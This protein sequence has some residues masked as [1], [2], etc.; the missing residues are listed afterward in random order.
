M[1]P[2]V[3]R[4]ASQSAAVICAAPACS[5][6]VDSRT[7]D[8]SAAEEAATGAGGG[9]ASGAGVLTGSGG[10][11]EAGAGAASAKGTASAGLWSP[12]DAATAARE[13]SLVR[14]V[15]GSADTEA[16]V[17]SDDIS[18]E[19]RALEAA[20]V[21]A[22]SATC[23]SSRWIRATRAPTPSPTCSD[24]SCTVATSSSTRGSGA[25]RI[26]VRAS[27]KSSMPRTRPGAPAR[28]ARVGERVEALAG[29]LHEVG[30]H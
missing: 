27:P 10:G 4:T 30:R 3:G 28:R 22:P 7:T 14:L 1:P 6:G 12:T 5:V 13:P 25:W 24:V 16:G 8:P 2:S 21:L 9:A 19:R 20:G 15:D 17:A 23:C 26:P 11:G 29:H 18:D